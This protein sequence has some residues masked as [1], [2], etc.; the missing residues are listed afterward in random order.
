[1]TGLAGSLPRRQH[2]IACDEPADILPAVTGTSHRI[3]LYWLLLLLP[4]L[5]AGAGA[6]QLLRREQARLAERAALVDAARLAAVEARTRLVAENVELLVGDVETGLLDALAEAPAAGLDAFLDRWERTNP[7]VRTTFRCTADGRILRPAPTA[8]DEE[9]R[10]FNRRFAALF[11][12]NP[13]WSER[14]AREAKKKTAA[15]AE[16][17]EGPAHEARQQVASNVAQVQSARRD[18]QA[19]SKA[20]SYAPRAQAAFEKDQVDT[21][22]NQPA[23]PARRGWTAWSEGGRL[24]LLGWVQPGAGEVRGV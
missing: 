11:R 4:T 14:V 10:G 8:D 9:A 24:H 20:G 23:A 6:I 15:S 13:P 12:D 1:M 5:A 21:Q 2:R 18:M 22:Q 3:Y 16:A 7:L 17:E 19:L